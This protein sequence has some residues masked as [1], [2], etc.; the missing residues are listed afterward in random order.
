MDNKLN[1]QKYLLLLTLVLCLTLLSNTASATIITNTKLTW[2][3]ES[4]EY[5]SPG[6]RIPANI[7]FDYE[8]TEN[9]SEIQNM[10]LDA[11]DLNTDIRVNT[12]YGALEINPDT[13][14]DENQTDN[15]DKKHCS[16]KNKVLQ[17]NDIEVKLP[18]TINKV[19]GSKEEITLTATLRLDN[20]R[21]EVIKLQTT[22]CDASGTCY[23]TPNSPNKVII[24]MQDKTASFNRKRIAFKLGNEVGLIYE[25]TDMTCYGYVNPTCSSGQ[26]IPLIITQYSGDSSQDDAGNALTGILSTTVKCD[27]GLPIIDDMQ[28]SSSSGLNAITMNDQVIVTVNVT[29]S[30]SS[31]VEMIVNATSIGLAEEKGSCS[32][33]ENG[34]F[35]CTI[36]LGPKVNQSGSY[37]LTA[38]ITDSA[39]NKAQKT[40]SF[41][42]LSTSDKPNVNLWRVSSVEQ[43]SKDLLRK[44]MRFARTIYVQAKLSTGKGAELVKIASS[45]QGCIPKKENKSGNRGDIKSFTILNFDENKKTVSATLTLANSGNGEND[46]YVDFQSLEYECEIAINSKVGE[47]YYPSNEK[48]N[49]TIKFE[50]ENGKSLYDQHMNKMTATKSRI[51]EID[52]MNFGLQKTVST[53]KQICQYYGLYQGA[54]ATVSGAEAITYFIPGMQGV[55]QGLKETGDGMTASTAGP[56]GTTADTMCGFFTCDGEYNKLLTGPFD[57]AMDSVG[58]GDYAF[59]GGY[60]N[61]SDAL[62]PYKSKW[63]AIGTMCLPAWIHHNEVE[64]SIECEFLSCLSDSTTYGGG[65]VSMCQK[66]KD[67]S[68]CVKQKSDLYNLI[69]ITAIF[70]DLSGRIA[71]AISSPATV[72]GIAA[73]LA[74][75]AYPEAG[76]THSA[77]NIYIAGTQS[78]NFVNKAK[79]IVQGETSPSA[80]CEVSLNKYDQKYIDYTNPPLKPLTNK[81]MEVNGKKIYL[82][83][84]GFYRI[85]NADGKTTTRVLPSDSDNNGEVDDFVIYEDNS[86]KSH[87]REEI[88]NNVGNKITSSLDPKKIEET[89]TIRNFLGSKI[90]KQPKSTTED[91]SSDLYDLQEWNTAYKNKQGKTESSTTNKKSEED[92]IKNNQEF[93]DEYF[94][95]LKIDGKVDP[96]L[97]VSN[98]DILKRFQ[99]DISKMESLNSDKNSAMAQLSKEYPE[100]NSQG[101]FKTDTNGKTIFYKDNAKL[102][103]DALLKTEEDIQNI[104]KAAQ[105]TPMGK[106]TQDWVDAVN[107]YKQTY[108]DNIGTY[109]K[110]QG[111]VDAYNKLLEKYPGKIKDLTPEQRTALFK[112]TSELLGTT[113]DK[114]S[115]ENKIM[116]NLVVSPDDGR[117]VKD[118]AEDAGLDD[119]IDNKEDKADEAENKIIKAKDKIG[120]E[121]KDIARAQQYAQN[122]GDAERTTRTIFGVA[123]G[124]QSFKALLGVEYNPEEDWGDGIFGFMGDTSRFL[125]DMSNFEQMVC[126]DR[127]SID[128]ETGDEVALIDEGAGS[129]SPGAIITGSR[130]QLNKETE[131]YDYFFEASMKMNK[132]SQAKAQIVVYGTENKDITKDMTGKTSILLVKNVPIRIGGTRAYVFSSEEK[133]DKICLEF[134]KTIK[135]IFDYATSNDKKICQQIIQE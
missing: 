52:K 43:S 78:L 66:N 64:K 102:F 27:G 6:A 119:Y 19:D 15:I 129:Y 31:Q 124:I 85:E 126:E 47:I 58:V 107:G 100:L 9:E 29:E 98:A 54:G 79:N 45:G 121:Y 24:E 86:L 104:Q 123:A 117:T 37:P 57:K 113:D 61:W 97:E 28:I 13:C 36:S 18:L 99:T 55:S 20:T 132:V 112:E 91:I 62:D 21:P 128:T 133:Y 118:L 114:G 32:K 41:T 111:K 12:N 69:P 44:N 22:T 5:A 14:V 131:K 74:C 82:D 81:E 40:Q 76:L 92:A 103:D 127:L 67:F 122:F 46:R 16:V 30:T 84:N 65:T 25:C 49:I 116:N 115:E 88:F 48:E 2:A 90:D 34:K 11:T 93:A 106:Q 110:E 8:L 63:V 33:E 83:D 35:I 23:A 50:L 59:A 75:L 135:S 109:D 68:Q 73:P 26:I 94:D 10:V 53:G 60:Q 51:A 3:G 130:S 42:L 77:C 101:I 71:D 17:T 80:N 125:N 96:N 89:N 120:S 1:S 72:A 39:G 4:I 87:S 134:D 70:K 108:Q 7:E 95:Q 105:G 38:I 56:L